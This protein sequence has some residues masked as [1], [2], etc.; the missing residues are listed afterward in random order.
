MQ[1]RQDGRDGVRRALGSAVALALR[2]D[3]EAVLW[4][5]VQ[6]EVGVVQGPSLG[7]RSG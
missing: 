3:R 7:S 1:V 5:D 2:R 6:R 4:G